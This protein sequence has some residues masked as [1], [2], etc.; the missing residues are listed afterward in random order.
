MRLAEGAR[1]LQGE[2][3]VEKR[4]ELVL[5]EI[6]ESDHVPAAK[7]CLHGSSYSIAP[8]MS[9]SRAIRIT[10]PLKASTQ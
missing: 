7:M 6:L 3:D 1:P 9:E 2:R 4:V 10:T 5:G 8:R